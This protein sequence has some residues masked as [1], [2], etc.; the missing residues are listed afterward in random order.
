M[1][2]RARAVR[3]PLRQR[4][5]RERI[6]RAGVSL[7]QSQGYHATGVTEILTRAR[8]PK[9]SFYHHFPGG[10]QALGVAA[11]EWLQAEVVAF[12]DQIARDGGGADEMLLGLARYSAEGLRAPARMRGSLLAVLAQEAIPDLIGIHAALRAYAG[13]LRERLIAAQ[14]RDGLDEPAARAFA[15]QGLAL[16]QGAAVMARIDA[17]PAR[18]VAQIADWLKATSKTRA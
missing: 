18:L 13:A 17:D 15:D 8:A 14:V 6:L 9:G 11:V 7:F 16:L 2:R 3:T 10:K 1:E 4:P 12:L 5:T